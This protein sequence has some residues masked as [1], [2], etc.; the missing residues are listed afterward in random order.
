[1]L[2]HTLGIKECVTYFLGDV[3]S[4]F[5]VY[6]QAQIS[7]SPH[8]NEIWRVYLQ[9]TAK[10]RTWVEFVQSQLDNRWS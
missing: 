4:T 9:R 2:F 1:M 10:P 5:K 6:S 8:F 3:E 7:L